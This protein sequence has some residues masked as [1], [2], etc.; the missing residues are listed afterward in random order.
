M[1]IFDYIWSINDDIWST[2]AM[3]L[4]TGSGGRSHLVKQGS[5]AG[6]HSSQGYFVRG[7]SFRT[8]G[9]LGHTKLPLG[10]WRPPKLAVIDI[11]EHA[12]FAGRLRPLDLPS[13]T[14]SNMWII[15]DLIWTMHYYIWFVYDYL[16]SSLII[17]GQ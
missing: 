8:V 16:W 14:S 9:S 2:C 13:S 12:C 5:L 4:M 1:V 17:S 11:I 10:A 7:M 3:T 15:Y 6:R